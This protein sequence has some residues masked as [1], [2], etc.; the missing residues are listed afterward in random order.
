[1]LGCRGDAA[2]LT[3]WPCLGTEKRN[4]MSIVLIIPGWGRRA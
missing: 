3:P 4:G 2:G 1:M